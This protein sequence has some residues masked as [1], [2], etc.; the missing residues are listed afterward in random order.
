MAN[1][2]Y[3][4]LEENCTDTTEYRYRGLCRS[5]TEYVKGE[6]VVPILRTKHNADGSL[7]HA[8]EASKIG[9]K[10]ITRRQQQA[11]AQ[12][13]SAYRKH[14]T[15]MRKMRQARRRNPEAFLVPDEPVEADCCATNSCEPDCEPKMD[16]TNI[17]ESV[18]EEE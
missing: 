3:K 18:G 13:E 16:L 1:Y 17:G 9:G 7:F 4:C 12:N 10:P 5:C 14:K 8:Q 6:P 11:Q 2:I 15:Q